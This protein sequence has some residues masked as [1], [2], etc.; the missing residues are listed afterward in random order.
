MCMQIRNPF[1]P[2][3]NGDASPLGNTLQQEVSRYQ[4]LQALLRSTLRDL[5]L[6]IEGRIVM[7][8]DLE[9]TM[10]ALLSNQVRAVRA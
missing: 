1:Q 4:Q 8:P 9:A 6:A 7:S 3:D 2:L 10:S 5:S